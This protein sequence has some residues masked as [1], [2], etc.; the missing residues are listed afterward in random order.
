[1]EISRSNACSK[2]RMHQ[3]MEA[4]QYFKPGT[5]EWW[6][7]S[8]G[9]QLRREQE[10]KI[11]FHTNAHTGMGGRCDEV[12]HTLEERTE[13]TGTSR[14]WL[15]IEACWKLEMQQVVIAFL[16]WR[17]PN[18]CLPSPHKKIHTVPADRRLSNQYALPTLWKPPNFLILS[19]THIQKLTMLPFISLCL[20]KMFVSLHI[21]LLQVF[22]YLCLPSY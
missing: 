4:F 18:I 16:L 6:A 3:S 9:N 20:T 8:G 2:D 13:M 15:F 12:S 11:T 5:R 19:Q 14:S 21:R 17:L 10:K 7:G 1:M 22:K